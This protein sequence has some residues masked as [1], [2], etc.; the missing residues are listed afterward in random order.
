MRTLTLT[1]AAG[2]AAGYVLGTR[3]GSGT[4]SANARST[5]TGSSGRRPAAPTDSSSRRPATGTADSA[6]PARRHLS[7][8][9]YDEP[10]GAAVIGETDGAW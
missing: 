6:T 2:L 10:A 4:D 3:M 8:V 7:T 1:F 5:S 9:D